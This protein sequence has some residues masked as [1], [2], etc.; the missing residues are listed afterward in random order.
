[1]PPLSCGWAAARCEVTVFEDAGHWPQ[2]DVPEQI[3]A[4]WRSFVSPAR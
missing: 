4:R 2:G 1:M 3:L